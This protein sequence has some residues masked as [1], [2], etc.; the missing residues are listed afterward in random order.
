MADRA[1]VQE[2]CL[3]L[4]IFYNLFQ[5]SGTENSPVIIDCTF[6]VYIFVVGLFQGNKFNCI[7]LISGKLILSVE[8]STP[9]RLYK[10]E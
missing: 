5:A 2:T 9:Y 10:H 3:T 6:M 1:S 4:I 8:L 7:D